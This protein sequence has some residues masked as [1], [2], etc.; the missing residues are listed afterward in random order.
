MNNFFSYNG[1]SIPLTKGY[2][3]TA[4]AFYGDLG[5]WGESDLLIVHGKEFGRGNWYL[6][7]D[8]QLDFARAKL[9]ALDVLEASA[10]EK[11][12]EF[13]QAL[14]DERKR[15]KAIVAAQEEQGVKNA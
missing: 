13:E 1:R 14:D 15:L 9:S 4:E 11:I 10:R 12:A 2:N 5:L 8:N 3:H 7:V 6:K